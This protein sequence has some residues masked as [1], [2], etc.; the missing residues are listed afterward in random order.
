MDLGTDGRNKPNAY[1]KSFFPVKKK[2]VTEKN[3]DSMCHIFTLAVT[4][5]SIQGQEKG[6][7]FP[8]AIY[9]LRS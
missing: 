9:K 4:Q 6:E 2:I 3:T 1:K 5:A 8:A 7:Y